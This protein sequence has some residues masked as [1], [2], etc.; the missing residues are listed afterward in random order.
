MEPPRRNCATSTTKP[1]ARLSPELLLE[2]NGIKPI[3]VP[4]LLRK[5]RSYWNDGSTHDLDTLRTEFEEL[6]LEQY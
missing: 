1:G 6:R 5:I 4:K 2:T 3:S